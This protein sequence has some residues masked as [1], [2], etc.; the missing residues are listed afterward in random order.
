MAQIHSLVFLFSR[1]PEAGTPAEGNREW[2]VSGT[3]RFPAAMS[4]SP[5]GRG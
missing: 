2:R 3:K 1:A 5:P 4:T